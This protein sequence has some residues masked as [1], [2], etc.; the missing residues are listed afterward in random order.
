M[1]SLT[2][3][4]APVVGV[5][6]ASAVLL[7]APGSVTAHTDF[8]FSLPTDGASVGEPVSEVTVAF[9]LPVTLVGNGF[10]V[11]DPQENLLMPFAVTDDDTV[12]RLQFDPP[13]AG[14]DVGVR[15][16][17]TAEDGHVLSGSFS[18]TVSVDA[19]PPTTTTSTVAPATVPPATES[20][21]TEPP[22][23]ETTT[24]VALTTPADSETV[25]D[26][27]AESSATEATTADADAVDADDSSS[28]GLVIA[29]AAIIA[30]L[31]AGFLL[32]RSRRSVSS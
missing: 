2:A 26:A 28:S 1:R 30:V 17:V 32:V 23:A 19:P 16:S 20:P 31:A 29:I 10:E 5:A 13:L 22:I 24:T 12:F 15:Y 9:T 21:A 25:I 27:T 8:D 14:G 7:V 4:V 3:L 18:F 11:L 6:L